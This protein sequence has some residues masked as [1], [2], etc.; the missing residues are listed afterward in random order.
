M[1]QDAAW[2]VDI[3][4]G[5]V[6]CRLCPANCKLTDGKRGI[7]RSRYNHRGQLVTDNYGELV[8][9]AVDPIEKK[10]LYHFYPTSKILSTGPNCCNLGCLNCQNWGISQKK[11][12]TTYVSPE[13]LLAAAVGQDSIGV[14][15][16]YTEPTMW[17]EYIMA[18]A[19]LLRAQGLK[20]VL[21][22]NGYINSEPLAKL[23]PL[24]DAA[25]VDLKS[26]KPDFY[27][28]VCKGKLQP[29]LDTIIAFSRSEAH[30]EVTNLV[31]PGHNDTDED[32]SEL[33][34]FVA[35]L[36][37]G[38]PLHF[39]AF[40]PDNKMMTEPTPTETL[41]RAYGLAGKSLDFVFVGNVQLAGCS[42]TVCPGCGE[43]LIR[44]SGYKTEKVGLDGANCRACRFET[45]IVC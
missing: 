35:G 45:Q 32:I 41:R 33:V 14:A 36:D 29:V 20:V 28:R 10:P 39:S 38:I 31:I 3:G 17:Y 13:D 44:R 8:T 27:Q 11:S 2:G 22:T 4:G 42:D 37:R 24:V 12:R 9:L 25:N 23:L 21:V 30:L 43:L 16:T 18:V 5:E 15:F 26:M 6:Q 1:I 34:E 7:C 19:P 40:H